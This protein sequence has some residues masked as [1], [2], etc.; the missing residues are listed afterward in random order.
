[1]SAHDPFCLERTLILVPSVFY[2]SVPGFSR[3]YA[4]H[5]E[6][7]SCSGKRLTGYWAS[8][9]LQ[10]ICNETL[11]HLPCHAARFSPSSFR[12]RALPMDGA[13]SHLTPQSSIPFAV[14]TINLRQS[15]QTQHLKRSERSPENQNSSAGVDRRPAFTIICSNV[16][17]TFT[18]CGVFSS[19]SIP[20]T[21]RLCQIK[22]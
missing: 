19:S 3:Q 2:P 11:L 6:G 14:E 13:S 15:S 4:F 16:W 18:L 1:M 7:C 9:D 10:E 8:F 17:S 21:L 5:G 22:A 20:P 12:E